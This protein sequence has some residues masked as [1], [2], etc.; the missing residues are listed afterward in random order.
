M[1]LQSN[2]MKIL[3]VMPKKKFED[4]TCMIMGALTMVWFEEAPYHLTSTS[5]VLISTNKY[6]GF[7]DL[8]CDA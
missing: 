6:D 8:I 1:H 5:H 3:L 4:C 7:D 2:A